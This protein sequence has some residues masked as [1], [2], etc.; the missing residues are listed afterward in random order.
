MRSRRM[1]EDDVGRLGG[2]RL[3]LA[4]AGHLADGDVDVG[5]AAAEDVED[6]RQDAEHGRGDQAQGE[7]AAMAER[8]LARVLARQLRIGEHPPRLDQEDAAGLGQLD[9]APAAQEQR[10][11]EVVLELLDA[12][13]DMR[14]GDAELLGG[15]AKMQALGQR[16][17]S[18]DLLEFHGGARSH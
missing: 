11:A 3:Q 16:D 12:P 15:M 4:G 7:T 13:A 1:D 6:G 9:V 18:P 5:I 8:A 17:E 2:Q 10:D 14:L